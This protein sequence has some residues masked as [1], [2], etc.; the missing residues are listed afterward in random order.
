MDFR[1]ISTR[2]EYWWS[3]LAVYGAIS[4]SCILGMVL[5]FTGSVPVVIL[6]GALLF[7]AF[8]LLIASIIPFIMLTIRR[9]HDIGKS[10]W[11]YYG[12]EIAG[13]AIYYAIT[14]Y[15]VSLM[16]KSV[17]LVANADGVMVEMIVRNS[18]TGSEILSWS[19]TAL[20][21]AIS[22]YLLVLLIMPSKLAN[23]KYRK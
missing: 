19:A 20:S 16:T 5:M 12:I 1:G 4:L 3:V 14:F 21:I 2:A 11:H 8:I 23:N 7:F 22:V 18:T 6:G 9:M 15:A 17:D 13:V 10:G